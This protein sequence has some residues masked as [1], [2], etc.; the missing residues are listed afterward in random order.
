MNRHPHARDRRCECGRDFRGT[1]IKCA[2]CIYRARAQNRVCGDCL[3]TYL[4]VLHFGRPQCNLCYRLSV[5]DGATKLTNR[6]VAARATGSRA[7]AAVSWRALWALGMR[8]CTYCGAE[9][10]PTDKAYGDVGPTHP[11]A[12]HV[13]P[14]ILGGA[15]TPENAVLACFSC[16]TSKGSKLATG[17]W[18]AQHAKLDHDVEGRK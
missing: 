11:T 7:L 15:N 5:E 4:G 10:D 12:D 8:F 14:L 13:V 1:T 2:A 16:N 17:I 6:R 3:K 9:C 18:P